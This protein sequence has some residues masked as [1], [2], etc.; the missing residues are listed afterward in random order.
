MITRIRFLLLCLAMFAFGGCYTQL[1]PPQPDR[2]ADRYS[3]A[4]QRFQGTPE[5]SIYHYHFDARR[6]YDPF[7]LD[8]FGFHD[9]WF[10]R[11]S[12]P[13]FPDP[14]YGYWHV[15]PNTWRWR[16]GQVIWAPIGAY[17]GSRWLPHPDPV[18]ILPPARPRVR[19]SG[20]EGP[21]VSAS[22]VRQTAPT[23]APQNNPAP[24]QVTPPPEAPK[25]TQ[26]EEKKEEKSQEEKREEKRS[27]QRRRGGMR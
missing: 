4:P 10:Y 7:G 14:Y 24:T 22:D 8:Q 9:P 18:V 13:F 16:S 26:T 2:P 3:Q 12:Y 5:N 11:S 15:M 19:Q 23:E 21:P 20:F 6:L 25:Q 27:D 1:R 17:V